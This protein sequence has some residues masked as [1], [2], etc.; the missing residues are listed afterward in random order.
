MLLSP[1]RASREMV[2]LGDVEVVNSKT[3]RQTRQ[4]GKAYVEYT[5]DISIDPELA[6]GPVWRF[7]ARYSSALETHRKLE[8]V[9]GVKKDG[10]GGGS[11][12]GFVLPPF[13]PKYRGQDMVNNDENVAKRGEELREYYQKLFNV[14]E[15]MNHAML[16]TNMGGL[17]ATKLRQNADKQTPENIA[18]G[19]MLTDENR[20][21]VEARR[22]TLLSKVGGGALSAVQMAPSL[23]FNPL[24]AVSSMA[25]SRNLDPGSLAEVAAAAAAANDDAVL[26]SGTLTMSD[27][28]YYFE[29]GAR[30]L[31]FFAEGPP[32]AWGSDKPYPGAPSGEV[33]IEGAAV[34]QVDDETTRGRHC[35]DI[36]T[37]ET[38]GRGEMFVRLDAASRDEL[39]DWMMA[40]L[41]QQMRLTQAQAQAES[42]LGTASGGGEL[43]QS[44]SAT[45]RDRDRDRPISASE[46]R[47]TVGGASERSRAG[48]DFTDD[49]GYGGAGV[50]DEGSLRF[51][52]SSWSSAPLDGNGNGNGKQQ[53]QQAESMKRLW[54]R[55]NE[56]SLTAEA[57]RLRS[58]RR[59]L[60]HWV[61][62]ETQ[63]VH[64][65]KYGTMSARVLLPRSTTATNTRTD[66]LGGVTMADPAQFDLDDPKIV[67]R[68]LQTLERSQATSEEKPID[69]QDAPR[70]TPFDPEEFPATTV[71]ELRS[72]FTEEQLRIAAFETLLCCTLIIPPEDKTARKALD[73][74]YNGGR[75]F[76]KRD[77][78]LQKLSELQHG[79]QTQAMLM[80]VDLD[81]AEADDHASVSA[82][83]TYSD[84]TDGT[85][86]SGAMGG[87]RGLQQLTG[88]ARRAIKVTIRE[89]CNIAVEDY[90]ELFQAMSVHVDDSDKNGAP[91]SALEVGVAPPSGGFLP[92]QLYPA[93][94]VLW[95]WRC[96][97]QRR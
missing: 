93:Q 85:D 47:T 45:D 87:A 83:S 35:F 58:E 24:A 40:V 92:P 27:R 70:A 59:D 86:G 88:S 77:V 5:F 64:Q 18:P 72:A 23:R 52:A 26:K 17:C 49:G 14:E 80:S 34:M 7:T 78:Y 30:T 50:V 2:F 54:E 79:E 84:G 4:D 95:R 75:G 46:L 36:K 53:Q 97:R 81:E 6:L 94:H 90:E 44:S 25:S 33:L 9:A 63:R 74:A 57:E 89:Q 67:E 41:E 38:A 29:L 96:V 62:K 82:E 61:L 19:L 16:E 12:D 55:Q 21:M 71:P 69:L 37:L 20:R 51:S 22:S 68:V 15:V 91:E 65:A 3:T 56:Y 43:E 60:L 73:D 66:G 32:P 48:S 10:G 8:R 28:P 13:P 31:R 11:S 39:T 1:V 76:L 42:S